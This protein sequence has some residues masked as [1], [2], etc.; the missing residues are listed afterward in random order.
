MVSGNKYLEK[1]EIII[2]NMYVKFVAMCMIRL[3]VIRIMGLHREQ[4]LKIYQMTGYARF[5]VWE[6][7]NLCQKRNKEAALL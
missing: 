7:I 3:L 6:K 1:E 2:K 5:A 4:H